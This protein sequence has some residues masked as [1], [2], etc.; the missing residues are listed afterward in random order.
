M[1]R[2]RCYLAQDWVMYF[3]HVTAYDGG[4]V[5]WGSAEGLAKVPMQEKPNCLHHA[6]PG[7]ETD[8][9]RRTRRDQGARSMPPGRDLKH[10]SNRK[11]WIRRRRRV[12]GV[13]F[14]EVLGWSSLNR[15]AAS[16]YSSCTRR[17]AVSIILPIRHI[18]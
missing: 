5:A 16:M 14:R 9:H 10:N 1:G 17:R 15:I 4:S 8:K 11:N 2:E 6:K 12:A 7:R 18:R 13:K 3:D